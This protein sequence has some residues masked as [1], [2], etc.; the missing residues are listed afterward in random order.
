MILVLFLVF[1][2]S[3]EAKLTVGATTQDVEAVVKAVGGD[4]VDTFSVAKGTQDPHQI[5][6]K[7]SFM[8]KFRGADLIV[9]QGLELETAWLLPLIQGSRNTNVVVGS[10]GFLELGPALDPIEVAKGAVSRAEG[11]VHP[12][13]NPHFQLDPVRLGQAA[14]L[15]AGRMGELDGAH[16]DLFRANAESFQKRLAEKTKAWSARIQKTGLKEFASYHKTFSYFADRF[17]LKNTL[18]LEPKPGIPPTASHIL[19]VMAAMKARKIKVVLIENFFDDSVRAKLE[20]EIPGVKVF[21]VPVYV[22][23]EPAIKTNADLIERVVSALE[24][25]VK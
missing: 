19:E 6:A 12:L 21:K 1:T 14:L 4:Q 17:G 18:Y 25:A 15:I 16:R 24:G 13:G 9:A 20:K 2:A 8:V 3:A 7:P 5:E 23:G 11:D 22:G 10:K